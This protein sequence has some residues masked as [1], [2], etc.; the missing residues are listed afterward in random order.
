MDRS[1]IGATTVSSS[2]SSNSTVI[3]YNYSDIFDGDS[4]YVS[5]SDSYPSSLVSTH[6]DS[7]NV[8]GR[9]YL[10]RRQVDYSFPH[11]EEEEVR[12]DLIHRVWTLALEGKMFKAP[13]PGS[14]NKILDVGTRTCLWAIDIA[15]Q[16]PDAQVFGT[17]IAPSK[18]PWAPPN[19]DVQ[20][21]DVE[22]DWVFP[23]NTFDL[24]HIR[25]MAGFVT[26]WPRLLAQSFTALKPGGY[27]EFHDFSSLFECEDGTLAPE[28][29]LNLWVK[30]WEEGATQS[31]RNW[32]TVGPEMPAMMRVVGF[33][34]VVNE[35]Y[36]VYTLGARPQE[37]KR[38]R[39]MSMCML[40]QFLEGAEGITLDMFIRV[41]G[42]DKKDVEDLVAKV[43]KEMLNPKINAFTRGHIVYGRK[44]L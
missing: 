30:T 23:E 40:R 33:E 31:G 6:A 10:S 4:D 17:D 43:R 2:A 5:G 21:E 25:S 13:I 7:R 29:V 41:L 26:D 38:L 22:D 32:S 9:R 42:W 39:E 37:D 24:I 1:F 12:L 34:N 20:L 16:Y 35:A 3:E 28:S 19:L 27:I 18:L 15:E 36:K 8:N 11:D 14:P 44:P